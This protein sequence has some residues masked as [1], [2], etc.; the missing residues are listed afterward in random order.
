MKKGVAITLAVVGGVLALFAVIG[1]LAFFTVSKYTENNK[2]VTVHVS[3]NG[4]VGMELRGMYK[5]GEEVKLSCGSFTIDEID[6]KGGKMTITVSQGATI[7]DYPENTLRL[8]M[9]DSCI[10]TDGNSE[11]EIVLEDIGN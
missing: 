1:I 8:N 2:F 5:A 3:D 6:K 10:V 4:G 9:G 11:A 7:K